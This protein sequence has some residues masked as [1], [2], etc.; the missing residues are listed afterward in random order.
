MEPHGAVSEHLNRMVE[1]K[2]AAAPS[3]SFGHQEASCWRDIQALHEEWSA[4]GAEFLTPPL[5]RGPEI[6]CYVRDPDGHLIEV[7]QTS[8]EFLKQIG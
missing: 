2:A 5:D 8:P 3:F 1:P 4:R 6:R 7:G